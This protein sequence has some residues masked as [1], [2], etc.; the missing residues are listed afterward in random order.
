MIRIAILE[1][2]KE[3]KDIV[4]LLAEFFKTT[5]WTFRHFYKASDLA[6]AM[7]EEKYQIFFFDEMFD[8][9]RLES[10]FVHDNPTAMVVYLYGD[11]QPRRAGETSNRIFYLSKSHLVEDL[12]AIESDLKTQAAQKEVYS[13]VY[14]GVKIDIP[15][16]DIFYLEKVGKN[17][18]FHTRKGE[19]HRRLN[20][21]D[22]DAEFERYGFLRVHISYLVNG[23]YLT[24][25]YKDEVELNHSMR[26]P[27][28]R[29]QKKKLGLT[30]RSSSRH[31]DA[32]HS[33]RMT[34]AAAKE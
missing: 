33:A 25:I 26:V 28:S 16:E 5:D 2:E 7:K 24:G 15:V 21:T 4:F 1:H 30:V 8:T 32:A 17:V 31:E 6:R 20:L 19:F 34:G 27:L 29:A 13:L 22:L 3:T 9:P 23:K 12:K 14:Q 11:P 10:V 18:H